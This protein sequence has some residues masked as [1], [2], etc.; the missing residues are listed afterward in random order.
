MYD[1]YRS[2]EWAAIRKAA[3]E[4]AGG[5]CE[6]CGDPAETAHHPTYPKRLGAVADYRRECETKM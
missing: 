6:F 5:K 3:I 1:Y 4:A 2:P